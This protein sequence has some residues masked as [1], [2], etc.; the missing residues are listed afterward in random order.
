MRKRTFCKDSI[1]HK[2]EVKIVMLSK[3]SESHSEKHCKCLCH[4]KENFLDEK[5]IDDLKSRKKFII[6]PDDE[7][8][9]LKKEETIDLLC[10][11]NQTGGY[12]QIN[13]QNLFNEIFEKKQKIL[14]SDSEDTTLTKEWTYKEELA[15]R[16]LK[17]MY[18]KEKWD[19]YSQILSWY[20]PTQIKRQWNVKI[21]ENVQKEGWKEREKWFFYLFYRQLGRN[22]NEMKRI[23]T[24]KTKYNQFAYLW[25]YDIIIKR[26]QYE[27]LIQNILNYQDVFTSNYLTDLERFL[28]RRFVKEEH[29]RFKNDKS[30]LRTRKQHFWIPETLEEVFDSSSRYLK[31]LRNEDGMVDFEKVI[32]LVFTNQQVDLNKFFK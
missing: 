30:F 7:I 24:K 23:F 20:S 3:R 4:E 10:K 8:K 6:D 12:E 21:K 18:P 9:R 22:W 26:P 11:S 29:Y 15:L 16:Y 1:H 28:I 14:Q 13:Y 2:V 31:D 25:N 27:N 32:Q 17:K 5:F 19:F